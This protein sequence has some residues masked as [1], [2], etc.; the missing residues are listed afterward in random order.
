MLGVV[1]LDDVRQGAVDEE[2]LGA[3]EVATGGAGSV[4]ELLEAVE[5]ERRARTRTEQ[6]IETAAAAARSM[7]VS[8][9]LAAVT[10]G[11]QRL[12]GDELVIAAASSSNDIRAEWTGDAA[13]AR[14]A[15]AAFQTAGATDGLAGAVSLDRTLARWAPLMGL[16]HARALAVP[17]RHRSRDLGWVLSLGTALEPHGADELQAA[18]VVGEQASLALHTTSLLEAERAAVD[19]LTELDALKNSFL[20]T[21]SHELRTPLTAILGFSELL[22]EEIHD[23]ELAPHL[24][25]LRREASVLEA[26]I[27]NLLDT[28]RLEAGLLQ[29]N[30]HPV[31]LGASIAQAVEVVGHG[32][33]GRQIVFKAPDELRPIAADGTRLRQ[34]FINLIENASKYS[35]NA[36]TVRVTIWPVQDDGDRSWIDVTIDDAGPGIPRSERTRVFERFRRLST[37]ERAPGTGIG[38]YI[39][40]ALVEAHG[41]AITVEDPPELPGSR[42]RVR[43]PIAADVR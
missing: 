35:P 16:G 14:R 29:L 20:A 28:S 9:A 6:V 18:A 1:V 17:L 41:G 11:L 36:S 27:G 39:V 37:H 2:R 5:S 21:V 15:I 7:T 25:D 34:V 42:F 40:K 3:L 38:L 31:D 26:L 43:L 22:A 12:T 23:P 30:V 32:H 13:E 10:H 4:L 33:P 19:R 24:D 8:A